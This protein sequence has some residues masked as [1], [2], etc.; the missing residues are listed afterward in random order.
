MEHQPYKNWILEEEVLTLEQQTTLNEHLE[1]CPQCAKLSRDLN[2]ALRIIRSAPEVPA[3]VGF[4]SRWSLSLTARKREEE[5]RQARSLTI[6]LA[7]SA[8]VIVMGAMLI[9][10]PEL[11]LISMTTGVLTA[12]LNLINGAQ[13]VLSFVV[14]FYKHAQP[15]SLVLILVVFGGWILLASFTLALSVWKL[16]VKKVENKS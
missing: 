8:L 11:S 13:S 15:T 5:K 16:A 9:F 2:T 6:A 10:I 1:I 3:P 14:N 4:T 7:S 12:I